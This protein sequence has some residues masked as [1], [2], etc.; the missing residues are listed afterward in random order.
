MTN[1]A[2]TKRFGN[3]SAPGR[4]TEIHL[5]GCELNTLVTTDELHWCIF[6]ID[7]LSFGTHLVVLSATQIVWAG[8][9]EVVKTGLRSIIEQLGPTLGMPS[10]VY[11]DPLQ[12]DAPQRSA[13]VLQTPEMQYMLITYDLFHGDISWSPVFSLDPGKH[14]GSADALRLIFPVNADQAIQALSTT[15]GLHK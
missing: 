12:V 6:D 1:Q 11:H 4:I 3:H 2:H 5:P 9:P 13:W 14:R 15:N 8:G 7:A 10:T